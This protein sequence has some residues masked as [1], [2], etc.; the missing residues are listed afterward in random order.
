VVGLELN[1]QIIDLGWASVSAILLS[2][3]ATVLV[4]KWVSAKVRLAII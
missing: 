4:S 3:L 1:A 2:I